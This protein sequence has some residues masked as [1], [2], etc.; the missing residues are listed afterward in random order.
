MVVY[1]CKIYFFLGRGVFRFLGEG[2]FG[3]G[4]VDGEP[5]MG[6]VPSPGVGGGGVDGGCTVP[7]DGVD[8]DA[9]AGDGPLL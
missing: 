5:G 3:F 9:G 7:A 6:G 8:V 2:A 1:M 4:V